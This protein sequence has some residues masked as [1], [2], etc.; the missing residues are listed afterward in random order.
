[1]RTYTLMDDILC[2]NVVLLLMIIIIEVDGE[3]EA[4]EE[5]ECS[6]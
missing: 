5:G 2:L 4:G 1:M 3:E 6:S